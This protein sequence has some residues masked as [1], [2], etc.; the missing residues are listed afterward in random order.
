MQQRAV[1]VGIFLD[2][3]PVVGLGLLRFSN[4]ALSQTQER[5]RRGVLLGAKAGLIALQRL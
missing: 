2:R 1:V 5:A 4:F 3:L